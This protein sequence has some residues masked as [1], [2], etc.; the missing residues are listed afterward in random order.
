MYLHKK[1]FTIKILVCPIVSKK[2]TRVYVSKFNAILVN[3][4]EQLQPLYFTFNAK[5]HRIIWIKQQFNKLT[6][7]VQAY[8]YYGQGYAI[9]PEIKN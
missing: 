6:M 3:S 4:M 1:Y 2:A 9:V 7:N 8:N 5:V